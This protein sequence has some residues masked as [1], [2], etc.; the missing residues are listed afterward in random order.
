MGYALLRFR[1]CLA[2]T[3]VVMALPGRAQRLESEPLPDLRI[4]GFHFP[5]S[6]ATVTGW[7]TAMSSNT[8]AAAF[9]TAKIQSHGWGLWAAL[10]AETA[11]RID[12]QTLRVFETW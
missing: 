12:G 7:L 1:L 9:A 3:C 5:E 6:E 10:T 4:P 8:P 2:A 11:Q